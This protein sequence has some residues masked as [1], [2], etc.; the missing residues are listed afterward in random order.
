MTIYLGSSGHVELQR[1]QSAW[2]RTT[3]NNPDIG[4]KNRRLSVNFYGDQ[5]GDAK[6]AANVRRTLSR[7]Q[8]ED[9]LYNFVTGDRLTLRTVSGEHLAFI[10]PSEFRDGKGHRSITRFVYLDQAGG[11]RLYETFA[12]ALEGRPE[13]AIELTKLDQSLLDPDTG[14]DGKEETVNKYQL[15]DIRVEPLGE[16]GWRCLGQVTNYELVS[17]RE[18]IDITA[19]SQAYRQQYEAGLIQGSG[20]INCFWEHEYTNC[21]DTADVVQY[22]ELSYFLAATVLRLEQGADFGA[23]FYITKN[24][25]AAANQSLWYDCPKCVITNCTVEVTPTQVITAAID[26]VT[27]GKIRLK[28]GFATDRLLVEQSPR[29]ISAYLADEF[30]TTPIELQNSSDV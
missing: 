27:T 7:E 25:G 11:M 19:M 23:R 13:N 29:A 16:S 21:L 9:S 4:V 2:L 18:N 14:V 20:R 15:L 1:P 28:Q 26:F 6:T 24:D 17:T 30:T 8:A 22:S 5:D 3:L 10:P 12:E